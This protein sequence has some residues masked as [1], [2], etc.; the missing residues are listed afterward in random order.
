VRFSSGFTPGQK[1]RSNIRFKKGLD[2]DSDSVAA[3]SGWPGCGATSVT[4]APETFMCLQRQHNPLRRSGYPK[5]RTENSPYLR[6]KSEQSICHMSSDPDAFR[7]MRKIGCWRICQDSEW[8]RLSGKPS[9]RRAIRR[10]SPVPGF[11]LACSGRIS[12]IRTN[13]GSASVYKSLE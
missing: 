2:S 5:T 7:S 6:I 13:S 11:P 12:G 8:N 3:A 1:R 9:P 4:R 10:A